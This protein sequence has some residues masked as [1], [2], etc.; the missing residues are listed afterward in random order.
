MLL[1]AIC[2]DILL[3]SDSISSPFCGHI[4][5]D[6]C[7]SRWLESNHTCPQ[8]RQNCPRSTVHRI[9]LPEHTNIG[10]NDLMEKLSEISKQKKDQD[11]VIK[12]LEGQRRKLELELKLKKKQYH[13]VLQRHIKQLGKHSKTVNIPR[14]TEQQ[15]PQAG[16]SSEITRNSITLNT[17]KKNSSTTNS[18]PLRKR[19]RTRIDRAK[20]YFRRRRLALT[21]SANN[22]NDNIVD[23]NQNNPSANIEPQV[24]MN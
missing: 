3:I 20:E 15:Q 8:C 18:R 16:P 13:K 2:A 10:S 9:Y 24:P 12:D 17:T 11:T 1:C 5:H 14:E 19:N 4:F 6:S 22:N 7:L 23:N 21:N